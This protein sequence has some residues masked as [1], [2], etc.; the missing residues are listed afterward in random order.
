MSHHSLFALGLMLP[1][2][3][4]LELG[5][6]RQAGLRG[7]AVGVHGG[8]VRVSNEGSPGYYLDFYPWRLEQFIAEHSKR[9]E[10][11]I[12]ERYEERTQEL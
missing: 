10:Q 5:S 7:G 1:P 3:L 6:N 4:T 12:T 11:A 9:A 2:Y 8:L